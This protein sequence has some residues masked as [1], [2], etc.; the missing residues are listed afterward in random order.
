MNRIRRPLDVQASQHEG[1]EFVANDE[2]VNKANDES[3]DKADEFEA[4]N[5]SN[6]EVNGES[7]DKTKDEAKLKSKVVDFRVLVC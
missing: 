5:E 7:S 6:S 1:K 2:A 4:S 3:S